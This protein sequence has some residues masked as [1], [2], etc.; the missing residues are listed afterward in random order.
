MDNV[1]RTI[2]HKACSFGRLQTLQAIGAV[3]Q[4][5]GRNA[6]LNQQDATG[7]RSI[8]CAAERGQAH[9]VKW[10][11]RTARR[12]AR[13]RRWA[14]STPPSPRSSARKRPRA[15][16]S[17]RRARSRARRRGRR[18]HG[19]PQGEGLEEHEADLRGIGVDDV[20]T[21]GTFEEHE[22][23]GIANEL[24]TPPTVRRRASRCGTGRT[25]R[26]QDWATTPPLYYYKK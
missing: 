9:V 5:A 20:R 3:L 12:S 17:T 2:V 8:D 26:N 16:P 4:A 25:P 21:L 11:W 7:K 14:R 15:A 6:L 13:P 19:V 23:K 18:P 22:L 10:H 1:R 24:E